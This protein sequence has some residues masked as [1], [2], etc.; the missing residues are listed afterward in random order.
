MKKRYLLLFAAILSGQALAQDALSGIINHYAAVEAIDYCDNTLTVSDTAGFA[1]GQA[2][3]L[4]QMQGAEINTDNASSFG[5]VTALGSAGLYERARILEVNGM[6]IKLEKALINTYDLA[7]AVQIVSMPAYEQ[8]VVTGTLTAKAWDGSTGGLLAFSATQLTLQADIDVSGKGFR[9]G[10]AALDYT[11]DCNFLSNFNSYAYDEGSIRGGK[12]GEG[13][14]AAPASSSRG[15]GAQANGG[16]GG[17]DHNAG[18]GGGA[19]VSAGGLGGENDNPS[20]FGCK[21]FYPGIG[22]K[23]LP[24]LPE[25]LFLGGGGGAGH[26]NNDVATDGGNGG[27]I[28]LIEW[29]SAINSGGAIRANGLSA[30][31]SNGDGGGGGGAGGTIAIAGILTDFPGIL[32]EARGGNGG[33]A[34][35]TN[36]A[37]CFGPGGGG[38]GGRLLINPGSITFP[39]LDGGQAG[40]SINST[41]C[42]TGANGALA[43]AEGNHEDFIGIPEGM[44]LNLPP[45]VQIETPSITVCQGAAAQLQAQVSGF[46]LSLQWQVDM[47]NGFE[48]IQPG[49]IFSHPDSNV[50]LINEVAAAMEN[51]SFRLAVMS[52]CFETVYSPAVTINT[53]P[54]PVAGFTFSVDQLSVQFDNLSTNADAY[55][56]TFGDGSSSTAFEPA[57][58]YPGAGSYNAT[59]TVIN[60]ICQDSASLSLVVTI[61]ALPIAAFE[62]SPATGCAPLTV[63]FTNL[64]QDADNYFWFFNGG[65]PLS[66]TAPNPQVVYNSPGVYDVFLLAS[67]GLG[68]DTIIL[69]HFIEV[70]PAP[71]AAFSASVNGLSASFSNQSA[72]ATAYTWFFGDG[73]SSMMAQPSHTYAGSGLYTVQ[74]IARSDCGA[75]TASMVLAIGAPPAPDF[76]TLTSSTGCAPL[77]ANFVDESAGAYDSLLWAFPGGTPASSTEENPQVTYP[78]PGQY[79]VQLT[80]YSAFGPQTLSSPQYITVYARPEPDFDFEVNG[81]TVSFSNFSTDATTYVWNFG[82]GQSSQEA[83]PVHTYAAPGMYNVTL[84]ASNGPC[85]KAVGQTVVIQSTQAAEASLPEGVS[86][87]PNPVFSTLYLQCDRPEWY[88]VQWRLFGPEGRLLQ[89]GIANGDSQWEMG[90]LP[91]GLYLMYLSNEEG[92][93]VVKVITL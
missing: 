6:A 91:G 8:A 63:N 65:T 81:L 32:I 82:D 51:Y 7:G 26:G 25:R 77:T 45:T 18:G 37:Q 24:A 31:Q 72:N 80:L 36:T 90:S 83:E 9:G 88:P 14:S 52:N 22:G 84:N 29:G 15:R 79:D 38:A 1:P 42:G 75:D 62:A 33:N 34:N 28:V 12:K 93:W 69:E 5:N 61:E 40:L 10:S 3:L 43:G 47:G 89:Q 11:G 23:A 13:V 2:L 86:V 71:Q 57:H 56:W 48:S 92:V 46:G 21:G 53:P 19:N 55:F 87:F 58:T 4:I 68:T 73:W 64:S 20:F 74:L 60:T 66:S 41:E 76:S 35:N 30:L 16:G 85:S 54:A 50:L 70:L 49:P 59:L 44:E 17:N 67:N 39:V 78:L 27:G